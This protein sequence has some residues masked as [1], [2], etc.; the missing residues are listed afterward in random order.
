MWKT[1]TSPKGEFGQ[2]QES[3]PRPTVRCKCRRPPR[4]TEANEK[5]APVHK[6]SLPR[7]C[8]RC[9]ASARTCGTRM[10][11]SRVPVRLGRNLSP[12]YNKTTQTE[13]EGSSWCAASGKVSSCSSWSEA[14]EGSLKQHNMR[15]CVP[16][17]RTADETVI[18]FFS[19]R[20]F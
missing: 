1:K 8:N 18:C 3:Y 7:R 10:E 15:L 4:R 19:F 6:V 17:G 16:S 5:K 2:G 13:N 12:D 9:F 20:V 14:T 11:S